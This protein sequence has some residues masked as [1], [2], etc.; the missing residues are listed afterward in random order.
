MNEL[1]Y[2][3]DNRLRIWFIDRAVRP[4]LNFGH[5]TEKLRTC[6]C[7]AMFAFDSLAALIAADTSYSLSVMSHVAKG[8][9]GIQLP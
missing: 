8:R 7:Y 2:V 5:E 3:R 4:V 1:D 9:L 6:R